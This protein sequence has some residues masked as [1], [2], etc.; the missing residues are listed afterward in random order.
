MELTELIKEKLD[1]ARENGALP[2]IVSVDGHAAAGKTTLAGKLY[3]AFGCSVIRTDDFFLP[4]ELRT[5]ERLSEP[6]GNVHYERFAEEVLPFIRS[7]KPFTYGV[8]DCSVMGINGEKQIMPSE[9]IIVEGSYSQ[10]PFFGDYADITVF[11]DISTEEQMRRV[12]LR[13]GKEKAEVFRKK[14]IPLENAYFEAF[15]IKEKAEVI[16][17]ALR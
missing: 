9:L 16:C 14:W 1:K 10:H 3:E 4:K 13:N 17:S 8:F 12:T 7:G 2:L 15:C 6:G 11:C 5:E